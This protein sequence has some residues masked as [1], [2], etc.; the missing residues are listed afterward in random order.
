M[1][2]SMGFDR[3]KVNPLIYIKLW[4][5]TC[6]PLLVFGTEPWSLTKADIACLE[7][8]QNWFIRKVFNLPKF[9]SHSFDCTQDFPSYIS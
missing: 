7:R 9:S 8:C 1:I 2:L 4:K 3:K 6:L 5:Q